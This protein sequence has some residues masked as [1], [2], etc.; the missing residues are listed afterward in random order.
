H[1]ME[2]MVIHPIQREAPADVKL[3]NL[4]D[5]RVAGAHGRVTTAS[6]D[7]PR[8]SADRPLSQSDLTEKFRHLALRVASPDEVQRLQDDILG[9]EGLSDLSRLNAALDLAAQRSRAG[10]ADWR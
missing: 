3:F 8:G 9:L 5:L 1:L 4:A 7:A 6:T 2:R 10:L